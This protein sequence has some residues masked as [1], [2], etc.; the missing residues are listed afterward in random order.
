M[1]KHVVNTTRPDKMAIE[2]RKENTK[3]HNIYIEPFDNDIYNIS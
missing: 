2:I 3:F 1:C